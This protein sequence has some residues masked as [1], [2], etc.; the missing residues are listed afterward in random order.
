LSKSE[1]LEAVDA[2]LA[3]GALRS[4]GGK[5]PKLVVAQRRAA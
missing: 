1:V 5:F 4:T 2:L 3:E